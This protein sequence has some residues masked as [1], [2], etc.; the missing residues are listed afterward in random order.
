MKQWLVSSE[1]WGKDR[2]VEKYRHFCNSIFIFVVLFHSVEGEIHFRNNEM[3]NIGKMA[4]FLISSHI[5][6]FIW[7]PKL[8]NDAYVATLKLTMIPA[9]KEDPWG[10]HLI[11]RNRALQTIRKRCFTTGVSNCRHW[12]MQTTHP[13]QL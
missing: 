4:L 8:W 12:I 5:N 7:K 13:P 10:V 2:E 6:T 3:S 11:T 1:K 9:G